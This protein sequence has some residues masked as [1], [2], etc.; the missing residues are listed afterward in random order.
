MA[1]RPVAPQALLSRSDALLRHTFGHAESLYR[2]GKFAYSWLGGEVPSQQEVASYINETITIY[3][4]TRAE[5]EPPIVNV[6]DVPQGAGVVF[7]PPTGPHADEGRQIVP[8]Y[9]YFMRLVQDDYPFVTGDW[10]ERGTGGGQPHYGMDV[11]GQLGSNIISPIDGEVVTKEEANA[12]RA[13]GVVKD[14]E[15][16]FFFHTDKRFFKNGARVRAGQ[17]LATIGLT[18]HTTGPH[19]HI[20]YAIRSQSKSD[21]SFGKYRYLVTDP[22]FF[23]YRQMYIGG[24]TDKNNNKK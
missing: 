19:V 2:I 9:R 14:R 7:Y 20:G 11:A 21:I 22:K 12:G 3:N 16:I 5:N 1:P 6:D 24:L 4:L 23:Y 8:V 18:G 13:I 10:C 15:V 17:V